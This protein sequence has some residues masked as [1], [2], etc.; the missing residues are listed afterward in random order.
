MADDG[1]A[2]CLCCGQKWMVMPGDLES[3][4]APECQERSRKQ[5]LA[6]EKAR[7]KALKAGR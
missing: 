4:L 2:T 1:M 7:R 6:A 3:S 5:R